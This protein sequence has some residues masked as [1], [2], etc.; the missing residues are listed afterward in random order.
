MV[1]RTPPAGNHLFFNIGAHRVLAKQNPQ[2]QEKEQPQQ[3][4]QWIPHHGEDLGAAPE[5]PMPPP[6]KDQA[7]EEP[8]VE[9]QPPASEEQQAPNPTPEQELQ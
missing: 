6:Q 5:A 4:H 9:Y 8:T 2:W 3:G 1:F 7:T